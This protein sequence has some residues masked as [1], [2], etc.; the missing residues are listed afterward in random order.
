MVTG[1]T[2]LETRRRI[3]LSDFLH[4]TVDDLLSTPNGKDSLDSLERSMEEMISRRLIPRS[5]STKV[6]VEETLFQG[7]ARM[8]LCDKAIQAR[9]NAD[10]IDFRRKDPSYSLGKKETESRS[11]NV[12]VEEARLRSPAGM[13]P[14][15]ATV[16]ARTNNEFI[17]FIREDP[18]SLLDKKDTEIASTMQLD[19]SQQNRTAS[20]LPILDV[21]GAIDKKGSFRRY[22]KA[23]GN[24]ARE[25]LVRLRTFSKKSNLTPKRKCHLPSLENAQQPTA[26]GNDM[27]ETLGIGDISTKG[28]E[29]QGIM[30]SDGVSVHR[31]QSK[32]NLDHDEH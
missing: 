16:Q 5:L 31:A 8:E 18:S 23:F 27:R 3:I 19:I 17:D 24:Q 7:L 6:S 14:C 11:K 1:N 9:T 20:T 12:P 4:S 10:F 2:D 25:T 32:R 28:C 29:P 26:R 13:E 22:L 30:Q 15:N 21:E